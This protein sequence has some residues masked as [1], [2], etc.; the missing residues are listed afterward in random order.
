MLCDVHKK[1][2]MVS[3]DGFRRIGIPAPEEKGRLR[4]IKL[5]HSLG[6]EY[7]LPNP[8]DCPGC[9]LHIET[10]GQGMPRTQ[11]E[12]DEYREKHKG[13]QCGRPPLTQVDIPNIVACSMHGKHNLL[14]Q[15]WYATVTQHLYDNKLVEKVNAVVCEEWK[16]K[17]HKHVAQTTKQP[18]TKNTPHFNGP[19]GELVLVR[20]D[21]VLDLVMPMNSIK[22]RV[23]EE[24]AQANMLWQL[25]DVLFET[26]S[27][28]TPVDQASR[29]A[30]AR[31]AEKAAVAY[32][33]QFVKV[34]SS[35][36]GTL[37]M[38][39]AMF[40][41]PQHIRDHGSLSLLNAQGLEACN[42]AGKQDSKRHCNGQQARVRKDGSMSRG[43]TTRM[44]RAMMTT[45]FQ[46]G[47]MK[48]TILR[49]HVKRPE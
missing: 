27:R 18:T 23:R 25:Q 42:Q 26:W 1:H 3:K 34:C 31:E 32:V 45:I 37:T 15:T 8:Y 47:K 4:R 30:L 38:H 48:D 28:P 19:E 24:R 39:Y 29:D 41:W 6:E 46:V 16:M 22:T 7:G 13:Q 2:L 33:K 40:H 14:A 9:G 44:A 20:R 5:S 43:R 17:R 36:D 11:K 49:R 35:S 12:R 10:H 21:D